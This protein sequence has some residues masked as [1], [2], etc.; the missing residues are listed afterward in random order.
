MWTSASKKEE[1]LPSQG[2]GETQA[3]AFPP[4]EENI[5]DSDNG[6]AEI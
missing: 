1:F 3:K 2:K 4:V 6:N 5:P